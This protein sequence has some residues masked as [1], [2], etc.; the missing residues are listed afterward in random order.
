MFFN[1]ITYEG[2]SALNIEWTQLKNGHINT[3]LTKKMV[4]LGE[5]AG[6]TEEE[7]EEERT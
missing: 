6:N 2:F 1:E 4:N 5:T 7:K 3:N